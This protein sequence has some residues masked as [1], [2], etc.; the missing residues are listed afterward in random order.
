VADLS[1]RI[2]YVREKTPGNTVL[3]LSLTVP[4]GVSF[5]RVYLKGKR[6]AIIKVVKS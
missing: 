3:P 5:L 2:I 4:K 6:I 1:G